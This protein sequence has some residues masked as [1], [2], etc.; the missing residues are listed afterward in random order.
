M[1]IKDAQSAITGPVGEFVE[2]E[3]NIPKTTEIRENMIERIM[4]LENPVA[5]LIAENAG[6]TRR[7][8][9]RRAPTTFIESATT[10]PVTKDIV[11]W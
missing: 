8:L 1:N 7:A 9:T 5:S 2:K 10:K 4:L 6:N 3:T 11:I